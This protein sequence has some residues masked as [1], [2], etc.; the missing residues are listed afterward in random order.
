M[1]KL[2]LN[3]IQ[4]ETAKECLENKCM[5]DAILEFMNIFNTDYD[6]TYKILSAVKYNYKYLEV[7]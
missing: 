5:R 2:I 3:K 1:K 6:I 7:K 4:Y